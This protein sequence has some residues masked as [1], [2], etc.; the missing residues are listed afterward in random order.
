MGIQKQHISYW[1][2]TLFSSQTRRSVKLQT[3]H[4]AASLFDLS[5]TQTESLAN[6]AGL[7]LRKSNDFVSILKHSI[8]S[9]HGTQKDLYDE[10]QISERMF[11]Y[12]KNGTHLKKE[13]L[14][15]LA[16]TLELSLEKTQHLL[17]SAGFSLSQSIPGDAVVIWYFMHF[18]QIVLDST[19]ISYI[20][21]ILYNLDLP[22]LMTRPKGQR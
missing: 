22:L 2:S 10:A 3:V 15:S 5:E 20:N 11:R 13:S 9:Y 17:Q 16:V 7:S 14:L 12:M 1:Q 18:N 19:P 21:E 8:C 6:K 4:A